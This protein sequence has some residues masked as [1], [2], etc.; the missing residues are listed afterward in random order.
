MTTDHSRPPST[1]SSP[2][3]PSLSSCR[4][5]RRRAR[6]LGDDRPADPVQPADPRASSVPRRWRSTRHSARS[7]ASSRSR[8][9]VIGPGDA[10]DPHAGRT[11]GKFVARHPDGARRRRADLLPPRLH[12]PPRRGRR[13]L[14]PHR[15]ARTD[16][17]AGQLQGQAAGRLRWR[18]PT[19]S[20]TGSRCACRG[21]SRCHRTWPTGPDRRH[22]AAARHGSRSRSA[23]SL[24]RTGDAEPAGAGPAGLARSWSQV[25][26]LVSPPPPPGTH[27]SDFLAAV[28]A[29]RR[30]RD[31]HRLWREADLRWRLTRRQV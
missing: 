3:R 26:P 31:E 28:S 1:S 7:L 25:C 13:D 16:Q 2:A 10:G 15:R 12:A 4:Q 14:G 22:R 18:A 20:A 8:S 6:C 19:W 30:A 29:E 24:G 9:R 11:I 17:L 21:P 23:S 5:R 27:P